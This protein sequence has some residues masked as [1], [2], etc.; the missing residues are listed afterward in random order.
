MDCSVFCVQSAIDLNGLVHETCYTN[1]AS[2]WYYNVFSG[3]ITLLAELY[4]PIVNIVTR[5]ALEVPW[6]GALDYLKPYSI[7]AERCAERMAMIRSK[8]LVAITT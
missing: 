1:L 3:S 5:E 7:V 6:I 8:C 4:P 2:V